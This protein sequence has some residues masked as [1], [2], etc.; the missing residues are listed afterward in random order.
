MRKTIKYEITYKTIRN[1]D[2]KNNE[3][4]ESFTWEIPKLIE[5]LQNTE[6]MGA[7]HISIFPESESGEFGTPYLIIKTFKYDEETDEIYEYRINKEKE[8]E[9]IQRQ[10][11][12]AQFERLRNKYE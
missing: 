5:S 8:N 11:E 6:K 10:R 7:T 9:E 3:H 12:L 2:F 1:F 4:T